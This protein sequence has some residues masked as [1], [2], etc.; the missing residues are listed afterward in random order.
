MSNVFF[1]FPFLSFLG[2]FLFFCLS[3]CDMFFPYKKEFSAFFSLIY[4]LFIYFF[5]PFPSIPNAQEVAVV[6][7]YVYAI[8]RAACK[9]GPFV[10]TYLYCIRTILYLLHMI[11][12]FSRRMFC[13]RTELIHGQGASLQIAFFLPEKKERK[14]DCKSCKS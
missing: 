10:Y 3:S 12:P 1:S 8:G 5:H 11:L 2:F 13:W 7:Y 9:L 4:F 14:K 6:C